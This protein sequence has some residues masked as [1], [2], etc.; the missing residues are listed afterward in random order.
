MIDK[1][2]TM[3]GMT[4][5]DKSWH[6]N[7]LSDELKEYYEET[8]FFRKWSELSDV[9]YTYTRAKWSG[10]KLN[11]P[12]NNFMFY[13]GVVY[14]IP[15]YTARWLFF[16]SAGK[17]VGAK[18]PLHEVRNPKKTHKLHQIAERNNL[19]K[20]KFQRVCENQLRYWILLP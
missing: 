14:M 20:E 2:H 11:F 15:K 16:R 4:K 5:Y 12:F 7:D 8:R 17:K 3:L 9:V 18:K 19:D 10:Y 6:E 1:W 13:L